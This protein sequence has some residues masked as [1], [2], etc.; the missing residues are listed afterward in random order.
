MLRIAAFDKLNLKYP[1]RILTCIL[2]GQP[3]QLGYFT[4]LD[5]TYQQ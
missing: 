4:H 3:T 5:P 2:M 1:K